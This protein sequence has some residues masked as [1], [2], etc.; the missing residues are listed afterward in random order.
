MVKFA[1]IY[2]MPGLEGE[3]INH[4]KSSKAEF[5]SIAVDYAKIEDAIEAAKKLVKEYDVNM[6]ELCGGLANSALVSKVKA[7]VGDK[8]AVGQVMYGPEYRRTLVD[9]LKL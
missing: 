4:V 3:E 2:A 1:F 6:I 5:I 9:L 8:V 7:A